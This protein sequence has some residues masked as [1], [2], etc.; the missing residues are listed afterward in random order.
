VARETVLLSDA[1]L[2]SPDPSE[3]LGS[4][5]MR[6]LLDGLRDQYDIILIDSPPLL[7]VTDAAVVATRADG[8]LLMTRSGKTSQAPDPPDYP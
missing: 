6:E 7:P 4:R 8:A 2:R 1:D 3:L 5:H